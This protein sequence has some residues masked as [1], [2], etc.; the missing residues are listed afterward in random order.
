MIL[1]GGV[2]ALTSIV[3]VDDDAPS[4]LRRRD[5]RIIPEWSRVHPALTAG[6]VSVDPA[7]DLD[8]RRKD[9]L[10]PVHH[11]RYRH[12]FYGLVNFRCIAGYGSA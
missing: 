3:N 6:V 4:S 11:R 2:D 1:P 5:R 10:V 12:R 9:H 7:L 8:A